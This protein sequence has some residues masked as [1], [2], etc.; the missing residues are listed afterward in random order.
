MN[1]IERLTNMYP[2]K[3]KMKSS[4][5]TPQKDSTSFGYLALFT[6]S[7]QIFQ[8]ES[9]YQY[10]LDGLILNWNCKKILLVYTKWLTYVQ[11][12]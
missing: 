9:N 7:A 11:A 4:N 6:M 12:I 3:Y 1:S 8:T 2:M 10:V 5:L